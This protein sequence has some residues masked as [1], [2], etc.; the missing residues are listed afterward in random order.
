MSQRDQR[1][2]VSFTRDFRCCPGPIREVPAPAPP[3]LRH[4]CAG[5]TGPRDRSPVLVSETQPGISGNA[6]PRGQRI[7]RRQ[8]HRLTHAG[9]ER[10]VRILADDPSSNGLFI[11]QGHGLRPPAGVRNSLRHV[12]ESH[13]RQLRM[14][15]RCPTGFA[16]KGSP[17]RPLPRRCRVIAAAF[18][19][20]FTALSY[21]THQCESVNTESSG[22]KGQPCVNVVVT[23]APR[24]AF[25]PGDAGA[26]DRLRA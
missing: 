9:A 4:G 25:E 10:A 6:R 14:R 18:A 3:L 15:K 5:L 20:V 2:A 16:Q 1:S 8:R 26:L 23:N 24:G 13:V 11:G 7:I 17:I 22:T 19:G 21:P 12:S